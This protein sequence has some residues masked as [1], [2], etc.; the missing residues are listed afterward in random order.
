MRI[1]MLKI[2]ISFSDLKIEQNW[3]QAIAEMAEPMIR[4][5]GGA[6]LMLGDSSEGWNT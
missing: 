6:A 3:A 4:P 5:A 2:R 1:I